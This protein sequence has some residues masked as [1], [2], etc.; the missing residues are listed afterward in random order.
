MQVD[1]A[2]RIAEQRAM[3]LT[4]APHEVDESFDRLRADATAFFSKVPEPPV[5]RRPDDPARVAAEGLIPQAQELFA[6]CLALQRTGQLENLAGPLALAARW[7]LVCLVHTAAGQIA[8][9]EEAWAVAGGVEREA[10][11]ARRLFTRKDEKRRVF[12]PA[13]GQSRYDPRPDANVQVK[14]ACTAS[15]CH[16][17]DDYAFS[18]RHAT[19]QF[20]CKR[21]GED[22]IAYFGEVRS[23]Q[24]DGGNGKA[25]RYLLKL[26]EPGGGLSRI[27]FEDL[28]GAELSVCRQDFLA[29]LY[30]KDRELRGVLNLSSSKLLWIRRGGGCFVATVAFGEDAP[31][32]RV[33]RAFRDDVLRRTELGAWTVRAYYRHGPGLARLV[34]VTPGA[35]PAVR[36]ILRRVHQALLAASAPS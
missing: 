5:Y 27:E 10:L 23:A 24:L 31:E 26:E 16:Q 22:F 19:H 35:R 14:L 34:A 33:F 25:R 13:T 9:A 30:S 3:T 7:Y 4:V 36:W 28:S 15:S 20:R 2:I 29:F 17:I 32:L 1:E 12:D 18:P 8:P 6:R 21:C 11:S